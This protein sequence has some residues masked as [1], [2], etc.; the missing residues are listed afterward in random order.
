METLT[1]KQIPYTLLVVKILRNVL[2]LSHC[3][4]WNLAALSISTN[5]PS[6]GL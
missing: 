1:W 5:F 2:N 6:Q 3:Q 4:L